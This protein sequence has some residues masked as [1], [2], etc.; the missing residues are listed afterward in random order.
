MRL[1]KINGGGDVV[2]NEGVVLPRLGDT[3]HLHRQQNRDALPS[4]LAGQQH[5][6]CGTPTVTKE[7]DMGPRLLFSGKNAVV[8]RI[9]RPEDGVVRLFSVPVLENTDVSI[10]GNCEL[11]SP[12]EL[13]RTVVEVVVS[14][15][16]TDETDHNAGRS[17]SRRRCRREPRCD[18]L[19]SQE[20]RHGRNQNR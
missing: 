7:D 14:D 10:L 16:T 5:C 1:I 18:I 2:G 20:R 6:G 11:D 17:G 8:I 3:I 13:N 19:R 9:E 4:Q 15:K 12:R